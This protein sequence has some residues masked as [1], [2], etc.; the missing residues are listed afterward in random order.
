[1]N[2][3]KKDWRFTGRQDE[4]DYWLTPSNLRNILKI[5]DGANAYKLKQIYARVAFLESMLDKATYPAIR[6][7]IQSARHFKL[8]GAFRRG[9]IMRKLKI[10]L[11]S[12]YLDMFNEIFDKLVESGE[13]WC[14]RTGGW[15]RFV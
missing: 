3:E 4:T 14:S 7:M 2:G 13:L 15:Y 5:Q 10:P 12:Y 8:K 6:E 11:T 9:E 1:M